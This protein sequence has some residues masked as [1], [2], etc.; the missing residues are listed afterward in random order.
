METTKKLIMSFLTSDD[1]KVSLSVDNPR[2]DITETE[3]N[4]N[5]NAPWFAFGYNKFKIGCAKTIIPTTHGRPINI[6]V[7]NE[8][9]V[10]FVAVSLS[11]LAL[12]AD[13][14]G[15]SAVANAIFIASGKLVNVSTFPLNCPYNL[16]AISDAIYVLNIL[17]TVNESIFLLNDVIIELNVNGIDTINIFFTIVFT[18]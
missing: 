15:T 4:C 12:A 11:F 3:I 16:V 10:L 7:N 6:D 2:E 17:F 8:N 9:D 18:L 14:A 5:N 13:I 1:R